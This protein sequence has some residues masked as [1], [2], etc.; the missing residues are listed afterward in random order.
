MCNGIIAFS[1]AAIILT[2]CRNLAVTVGYV[3]KSKPQYSH[4][5]CAFLLPLHL[6]S[7]ECVQRQLKKQDR[8]LRTQSAVQTWLNKVNL[9]LLWIQIVTQSGSGLTYL[10]SQLGAQWAGCLS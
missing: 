7:V 1:P 5:A 4:L 10:N 2:L 6:C 8:T 3:D 9:K